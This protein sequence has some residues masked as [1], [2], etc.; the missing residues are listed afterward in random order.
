[1]YS[2]MFKISKTT[3]RN[4]K[5]IQNVIYKYLGTNQKSSIKISKAHHLGE[6]KQ[7]QFKI[8]L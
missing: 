2:Y 5:K 3:L 7:K 6:E 8:F 4:K 1:M